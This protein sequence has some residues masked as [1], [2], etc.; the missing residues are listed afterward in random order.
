MPLDL[1]T[2]GTD[3]ILK[4]YVQP[5][6]SKNQVAGLH[7]DALKIRLTAP[8]VDGEANKMCTQYLAKLFKLPKSAVQLVA[9]QT[10]RTK[11]FRLTPP[12]DK[13]DSLKKHIL[14]LGNPQ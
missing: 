10:S 8:P 6:A 14:S 2:S 3:L 9:G 11:T 13:R 4:I 1:K 7:G 5:R 12:A